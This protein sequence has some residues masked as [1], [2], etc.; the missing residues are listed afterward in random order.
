LEEATA[1]SALPLCSFFS[2]TYASNPVIVNKGIVNDVELIIHSI[3]YQ[4]A[5]AQIVLQGIYP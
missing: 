1:L 5:L 3:G 4:A 2:Y